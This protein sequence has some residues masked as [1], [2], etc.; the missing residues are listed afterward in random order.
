[1]MFAHRAERIGRLTTL[2]YATAEFSP[3]VPDQPI[4]PAPGGP[5]PPD[6][7]PTA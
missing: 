1:M 3:P 6:P 5:T 2:H 7:A 4:P